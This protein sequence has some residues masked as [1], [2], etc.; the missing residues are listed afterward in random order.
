MYSNN[1]FTFKSDAP[2][3]I[4]L[5]AAAMILASGSDPDGEDNSQDDPSDEGE[6]QSEEDL[7]ES[8]TRGGGDSSSFSVDPARTDFVDPARTRAVDPARTK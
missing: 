5:L 3:R 1:S 6:N 8:Q 7:S 2:A 4:L